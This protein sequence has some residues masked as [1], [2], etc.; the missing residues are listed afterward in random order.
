MIRMAYTEK[1]MFPQAPASVARARR[2]SD[3]WYW[4]DLAY[5]QGRAVHLEEARR[6][7][8]HMQRLSREQQVDQALFVRAYL[9]IGD[10]QQALASLEKAYAEHSDVMTSL[11]VDPVFDPLRS[12]TR[13]Q[14]L[15]RRVGLAH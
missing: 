1:S 3:P 11:K 10:K 5:I 15:L 6:A 9:G 14:D 8:R 7:L 4:A 13:F 2:L 12:E